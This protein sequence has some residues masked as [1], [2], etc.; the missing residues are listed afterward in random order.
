MIRRDARWTF[1]FTD[2]KFAD[3]SV[4]P[5]NVQITF[6]TMADRDCCIVKNMASG[7]LSMFS[8]RVILELYSVLSHFQRL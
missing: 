8:W 5:L 1:V 7:M 3:F 2:W 6:I 4:A